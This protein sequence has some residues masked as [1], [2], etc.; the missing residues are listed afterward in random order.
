MM[1]DSTSLLTGIN[2]IVL[3]GI[4]VFYFKKNYTI[5]DN[6]TFQTLVDTYE[7]ANAE[8]QSETPLSGGVGFQMY[9]T[10]ETYADE[11]E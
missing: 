2:T 6:D 7:E 9:D 3:I 10:E 4:C 11:D 5:L 1:I 8:E